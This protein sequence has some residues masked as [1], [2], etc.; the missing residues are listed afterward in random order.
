MNH[1]YY[2]SICSSCF[3]DD[4]YEIENVSTEAEATMLAYALHKQKHPYCKT[5]I[6]F[7]HIYRVGLGS[8]IERSTHEY[9]NTYDITR[10]ETE[11]KEEQKDDKHTV[12]GLW[13][14]RLMD[15]LDAVALIFR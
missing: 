12:R 15:F 9:L 2:Q 8:V 13:S 7:F 6:K 10:K 14:A 5:E 11:R 4:F 1:S 3:N